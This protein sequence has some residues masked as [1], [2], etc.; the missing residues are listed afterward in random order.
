MQLAF[1]Y[2]LYPKEGICDASYYGLLRSDRQVPAAE[3]ENCNVE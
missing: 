3:Q 2:P 1:G